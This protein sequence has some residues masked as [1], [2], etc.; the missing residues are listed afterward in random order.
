MGMAGN[1]GR[2]TATDQ[3]GLSP[4]GDSGVLTSWNTQQT[5]Q[6][7]TRFAPGASTAVQHSDVDTHDFQND[8]KVQL[9][10]TSELL[11]TEVVEEGDL[12]SFHVYG[13]S[14]TPDVWNRPEIQRSDNANFTIKL[15]SGEEMYDIEYAD[16]VQVAQKGSVKFRT[17]GKVQRVTVKKGAGTL[18]RA[19]GGENLSA[20]HDLLEMALADGV[21][22]ASEDAKLSN[23][24][25]KYGISQQQHDALL[26]KLTH[27]NTVF[28]VETSTGITGKTIMNR[29]VKREDIVARIV[30]TWELAPVGLGPG[31]GN[32][33]VFNINVTDTF[34][35][36]QKTDVKRRYTEFIALHNILKEEIDL[37]VKEH[38]YFI[39]SPLI[40]RAL[41]KYS[42]NPLISADKELSLRNH[43]EAGL[44]RKDWEELWARLE[45]A[46]PPASA[47]KMV[48]DKARIPFKFFKELFPELQSFPT[49]DYWH[50]LDDAEKEGTIG[51][52][53]ARHKGGERHRCEQLKHKL[54]Q[55]QLLGPE[56]LQQP[57]TWGMNSEASLPLS[58]SEL[59]QLVN[60]FVQ[61]W[62]HILS[63]PDVE[64]EARYPSEKVM[65]LRRNGYMLN[66][67]TD[68]DTV[69]LE[70]RDCGQPAQGS[71][72]LLAGLTKA[73][74]PKV[75]YHD[76]AIVQKRAERFELFLRCLLQM[77]FAREN[78]LHELHSFLNLP[79]QRPTKT[80]TAQVVGSVGSL[81]APT[82]MEWWYE[83]SYSVYLLYTISLGAAMTNLGP[84]LPQLAKNIGDAD[85]F[86]LGCVI[87]T[88]GF[89][90]G[91]GSC[92]SYP[93]FQANK[94]TPGRVGRGFVHMLLVLATI[95]AALFNIFIP[96]VNRP[97][98]LVLTVLC[99]G[100][101]LGC[102][103]QGVDTHVRLTVDK[104]KDVS[105]P[106]Q[107]AF[108]SFSGGYNVVWSFGAASSAL[109]AIVTSSAGIQWTFCCSSLFLVLLAMFPLTLYFSPRIFAPTS[110]ESQTSKDITF[111][112][113]HARVANF[114]Q[115]GPFVML[116]LSIFGLTPDAGPVHRRSTAVPRSPA[117]DQLDFRARSMGG[118]ERTVLG[119]VSCVFLLLVGV[120][121]SFTSFLMPYADSTIAGVTTS[122]ARY[123]MAAFWGANSV[124][125][126][127]AHSSRMAHPK[128]RG[129]VKYCGLKATTVL[130]SSVCAAVGLVTLLLLLDT[131]TATAPKTP[132]SIA[133]WWWVWVAML[134]LVLAL[135][136]DSLVSVFNNHDLDAGI[137]VEALENRG[138]RRSSRILA[139]VVATAALVGSILIPLLIGLV[140]SKGDYFTLA[141]AALVYLTFLCTARLG[142]RC[143][144]CCAYTY[145]GTGSE[146][147]LSG[148]A[149]DSS[150]AG[151]GLMRSPTA[152]SQADGTVYRT[153]S[154]Y[155][156]GV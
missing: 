27:S 34:A 77:S 23:A 13:K 155:P 43:L 81:I 14:I 66:C 67:A 41:D 133:T 8:L 108:A 113:H 150:S 9:G 89:G 28:H 35:G 118:R 79:Y 153:P 137:L 10:G 18:N 2:S 12:I 4:R 32:Y 54:V 3:S 140:W 114:W 17:S 117:N 30:P 76:E 47:V 128:H 129:I 99:H 149:G 59:C 92:M 64:W 29:N 97:F 40:L 151:R 139:S 19:V 152:V 98:A 132:G 146:R 71:V 51:I 106:S 63:E 26:T 91:V 138:N 38:V 124:G 22:A 131:G 49:N 56:V 154:A 72:V 123:L 104:F 110:T 94:P 15:F 36:Y 21:L 5:P 61:K 122:T 16:V 45:R 68:E 90:Y 144:K 100:I 119:M 52:M 80:P 105:V 136:F 102:M 87:A 96:A 93:W 147:M 75:I 141:L 42:R 127:I 101:C 7:Q 46:S 70:G 24:R 82:N 74:P 107:E 121:V 156:P 85:V 103:D 116:A 120:E 60:R 55:L 145:P 31:D 142:F 58:N 88:R 95:G 44:M 148:S 125:R 48:L 53:L 112:R 50:E 143:G 109:L 6:K 134:G 62:Y 25:Q 33:T 84:V 69:T 78:S 11:A 111:D 20:Y 65:K 73:M 135:A 57:T 37:W 126:F 83:R 130:L 39:L 86:W 115:D 1:I